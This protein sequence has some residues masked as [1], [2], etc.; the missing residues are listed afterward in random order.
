VRSDEIAAYKSLH[1]DGS[2]RV[3]PT[4]LAALNKAEENSLI[5][6]EDIIHMKDKESTALRETVNYTAHHKKCKIYC[7]TH[8]VYK[9]GV[10]SFMPLFHYIVFTNSPA[11]A[12]IMKQVLATFSP[13]KEELADQLAKIA[14]KTRQLKGTLDAYFFFDC[15]KRAMGWSTQSL[16]KSSSH[17]FDDDD[18]AQAALPAVGKPPSTAPATTTTTTTTSANAIDNFFSTSDSNYKAA[19]GLF[20]LIVASPKCQRHLDRPS[21]C[22]VF[23][24]AEGKKTVRVSLIDYIK[25]ALSSDPQ[26]KPRPEIVAANRLLLNHCGIPRCAIANRYLQE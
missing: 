3:I 9:T 19:R 11:N 5:I 4:T 22:F 2:K 21:L 13:T 17:L 1:P 14:E 18:G 26:R 10:Y 12:P 25:E 15:A 20:E 23:R 8:T 16:T 7:V 6:V 24:K